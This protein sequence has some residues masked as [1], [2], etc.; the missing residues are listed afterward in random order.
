MENPT[1]LK[2]GKKVEQENTQVFKE[3]KSRSI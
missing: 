1:S 3:L 2:V